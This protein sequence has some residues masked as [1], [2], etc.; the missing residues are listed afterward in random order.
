MMIEKAFF[1]YARYVNKLQSTGVPFD[2]AAV[3]ADRERVIQRMLDAKTLHAQMHKEHTKDTIPEY[4]QD[5]DRWPAYLKMLG[6]QLPFDPEWD[7]EWFQFQQSDFHM[8]MQKLSSGDVHYWILSIAL[9]DRQLYCAETNTDTKYGVGM[10][11][12]VALE[13]LASGPFTLD[14]LS[15][16]G[17]NVLGL[18]H[19]RVAREA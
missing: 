10:K 19:M 5:P 16:A 6:R 1:C 14:T 9:Q 17:H 13:G 12:V 7:K 4:A 3:E 11:T 2:E 18:S 8:S 15:S